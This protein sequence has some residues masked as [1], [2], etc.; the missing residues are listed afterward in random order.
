MHSFPLLNR[1]QQIGEHKAEPWLHYPL[2]LIWDECEIICLFG[3]AV[4]Q[5]GP[6]WCFISRHLHAQNSVNPLFV[7]KHLSWLLC[8]SLSPYWLLWALC[9]AGCQWSWSGRQPAVGDD[10]WF[11]RCVTADS[12]SVLSVFPAACLTV[13]L[14]EYQSACLWLHT[15]VSPPVCLPAGIRF[16]KPVLRCILIKSN[17]KLFFNWFIHD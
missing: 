11:Q 7:F 14:S 9:L 15:Q 4:L 10:A 1:P 5:S 16:T 8:V 3:P 2:T 12:G 6:V 17:I 13:C